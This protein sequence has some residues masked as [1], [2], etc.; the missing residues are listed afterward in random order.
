MPTWLLCAGENDSN[1][2]AATVAYTQS[3]HGPDTPEV[4]VARAR[5]RMCQPSVSLSAGMTAHAL[6][7]DAY[8]L[9]EVPDQIRPVPSSPV[10]GSCSISTLSLLGRFSGSVTLAYIHGVNDSAVHDVVPRIAGLIAKPSMLGLRRS[11]VAFCQGDHS[12]SAP[13]VV[14]PRTRQR[15]FIPS[16]SFPVGTCTQALPPEA[17]AVV[18]LPDQISPE[19]CT[20]AAGSCSISAPSTS[21]DPPASVTFAYS[22]GV[23]EA[24][25]HASVPRVA[26]TAPRPLPAVP[27]TAT[28]AACHSDHDP[29]TPPAVDTRTRQRI[30]Q[31]SFNLPDATT[32]VC[33][34]HPKEVPHPPEDTAP[35]SDQISPE[36]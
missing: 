23:V 31:P 26:G 32:G 9:S 2:S 21:F 7:P 8:S 30:S 14:T 20:V 28:V 19:P 33:K 35:A 13:A 11:T 5:Q 29:A 15:T 16:V 10:A 34:E 27:L 12:P 25:V 17:Y 22:H 4:V 6:V 36:P 1:G 3:D 24:N 18:P